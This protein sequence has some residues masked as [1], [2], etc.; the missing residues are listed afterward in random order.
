LDYANPKIGSSQGVEFYKVDGGFTF[1]QRLGSPRWVWANSIRGGYLQN[2]SSLPDS[3]VPTDWSFILGGIY[4]IRGFD[5]SSPKNRVPKDGNAG[6]ELG[7]ANEKLI[8]TS[9]DYYLF[10]SEFR[11]P[12]YGDWGGVLFYDGGAVH[13]AGYDFHRPYRDAVGF[14]IRYNTPVGPAAVDFAFKIRPERDEEPFRV[15][16]SIGTF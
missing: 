6:F 4:T 9:S 3:G 10:K 14:G 1:Y 16:V 13:I 5:L 11:V 2:L 7:Q 15:H 12:I 8:R